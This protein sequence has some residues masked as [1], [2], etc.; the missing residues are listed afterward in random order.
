MNLLPALSEAEYEKLKDSLLA[1]DF[2]PEY[3]VVLDQHGEV[4]DGHH[5]LRACKELGIE[6]ITVTVHVAT[7]YDRMVRAIMPNIAR[8]NLAREERLR[9]IGELAKAIPRPLSTS[10]QRTPTQDQARQASVVAT[11]EPFHTPANELLLAKHKAA[12]EARE[13]AAKVANVSRSQAHKDRRTLERFEK[14]GV[15]D[16]FIKGEMSLPEAEAASRPATTGYDPDAFDAEVLADRI[17]GEMPKD[18]R[19]LPRPAAP[20]TVPDQPRPPEELALTLFKVSRLLVGLVP[21]LTARHYYTLAKSDIDLGKLFVA[22]RTL[23]TN[24]V[25]ARRGQLEDSNG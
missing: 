13:Q 11:Q 21:R 4:L 1:H 22:L 10:T 23:E 14:A 25:K 20:V 5:R 3:P 12:S 8:R 17:V 2:M 15:A 6:P 24:I 9:L 18:A 16:K 19:F 7:E